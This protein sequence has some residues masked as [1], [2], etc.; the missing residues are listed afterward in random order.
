M[1]ICIEGVAQT[2]EKVT[3]QGT[4]AVAIPESL[5]LI[6]L[7]RLNDEDGQLVIGSSANLTGQG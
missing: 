7:V 6:E 2:M 5:F 1:V 3:K 4:V